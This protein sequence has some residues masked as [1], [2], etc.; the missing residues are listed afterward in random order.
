LNDHSV[1]TWGV[2]SSGGN[3]P[4]DVKIKLMKNDVT[5]VFPERNGFQ[6]LCSNGEMIRWEKF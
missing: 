4:E 3:I 1:L 2:E 6:V 5:M